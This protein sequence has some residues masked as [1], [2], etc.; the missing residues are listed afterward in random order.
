MVELLWVLFCD[1]NCDML[2]IHL[3]LLIMLELKVIYSYRGSPT[4]A[5]SCH[6]LLCIIHAA[7]HIKKLTMMSAK[8]QMLIPSQHACLQKSV[9]AIQLLVIDH[10]F[11]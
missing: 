4:L 6:V 10:V 2:I 11:L 5:V 7:V 9:Q 1:V 8:V 3:L